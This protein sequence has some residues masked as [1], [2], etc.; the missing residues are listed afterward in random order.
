MIEKYKDI[1][2]DLFKIYLSI[3]DVNKIKVFQN[4]NDKYTVIDKTMITSY[5]YLKCLNDFDRSYENGI[6]V[7]INNL[8]KPIIFS[9]T[10][11]ICIDLDEYNDSKLFETVINNLMEEKLEYKN[12]L[13][14]YI[15]IEFEN[16]YNDKIYEEY[17]NLWN[18]C[19]I[20]SEIFI[21]LELYLTGN[22][23]AYE[24]INERI[25]KYYLLYANLEVCGNKI[26]KI[27]EEF[28]TILTDNKQVLINKL[29]T[30]KIISEYYKLIQVP[31]RLKN[32]MRYSQ[33][34]LL[35]EE[36]VLIHTYIDTIINLLVCRY[37]IRQGENINKLELVIKCLFHDFGEYKG[38]EIITHI[39]S[40]SNKTK[41][42]F[43][44]IEEKDENDLKYL[45][46]DEFLNIV[47]SYKIG[48]TGYIS[49]VVD[50][51]LGVMKVY[52]E[53]EY[54]GNYNAIKTINALYR[55]RI[56]K[57][58]NFEKVESLKDKKFLKNLVDY[59]FMY[60]KGNLLNK[61]KDSM[62]TNYYTKKELEDLAAEINEWNTDLNERCK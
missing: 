11:N 16:D 56:E 51:I 57:F 3:I 24:K 38:N 26:S 55:G 52:I 61:Y 43:S 60:I 22:E 17:K 27:I 32:V 19:E 37:L 41:E 50:K 39:K 30:N 14:K 35:V 7:L 13:L 53:A 1:T 8:L 23:Y 20:V 12:R 58:N 54:M 21:L 47:K 46:G 25:N 15:K 29:K 59:V 4:I 31:L 42:I 18:E 10:G 5:I 33:I 36:D 62:L 48:C 28:K 40:Y 34:L 9:E 6:S 45:I 49:D 2:E 44:K